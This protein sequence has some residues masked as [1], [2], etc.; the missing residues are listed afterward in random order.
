MLPPDGSTMSPNQSD[1]SNMPTDMPNMS[2]EMPNIPMNIP[3]PMNEPTGGPDVAYS[4]TPQM[5]KGVFKQP[6][7][8]I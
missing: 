5:K 3:G 6:H 2:A 1:G 7:E 4:L 8:K